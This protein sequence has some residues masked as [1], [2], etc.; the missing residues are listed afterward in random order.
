MFVYIDCFSGVSGDMLL[1]AL[2]EIGF[3]LQVLHRVI[4]QFDLGIE[5]D[6]R[7]TRVQGMQARSIKIIDHSPVMRHLSDVTSLVDKTDLP[8]SVKEK[9]GQV[10]GLLAETEAQVH[11]IPVNEV[12]FH[13][14]GAADTLVD[15]VGFIY[16]LHY[17]GIHELFSASIPWSDGLIKMQHGLYPG[18]APATALLLKGMPC[19][20]VKAGM[21]LVTPTGAALLKALQPQFNALPPFFPEAVGYGAGS[22]QRSDSVPNVLRLI[23]GKRNSSTLKQEGIAVLETHIDDM[24]AEHYAFLCETLLQDPDIIDVYTSQILMKKAR[25]GYLLTVLTR[26]ELVTRVSSV[27]ILNSTSTGVRCS[28][29]SRLIADR[30]LEAVDSPWGSITVK[31]VLLPDG[32][33]RYKPEYEDCK[34]YA[35]RHNLPIMRIYQYALEHCPKGAGRE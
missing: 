33:R 19:Y 20:G 9:T 21:E 22:K 7:T 26:P 28:Y 14:I 31:S 35:R 3:P 18:P 4:E 16:G 34:M 2:I 8:A 23:L 6:S 32:I 13:E 24:S 30:S 5:I 29:Q 17:L 11:G 27:I 25:P 1:A 12:H 10:F 15:I